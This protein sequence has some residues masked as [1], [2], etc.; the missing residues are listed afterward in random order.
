MNTNQPS[1]VL[2]EAV[3]PQVRRIIG[4]RAFDA[5]ELVAYFPNLTA[6]STQTVTVNVPANGDLLVTELKGITVE[7]SAP[8]T[9]VADAPVTVQLRGSGN[10]RQW[11]SRETHIRTVIG[12]AERPAPV[13]PFRL[14]A[15]N[16]GV[17]VTLSHL[18]AGG[19]DYTAWVTLSGVQVFN[20]DVRW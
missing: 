8:G 5:Y 6:G 20:T 3:V 19:T 2:A 1:G 18:V 10:D 11:F 7:Q 17:S 14:V 15:A 12:T 4:N 13:N 9:V 16:S